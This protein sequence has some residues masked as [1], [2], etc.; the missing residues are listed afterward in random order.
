MIAAGLAAILVATCTI[1]A[2]LAVV[3]LDRPLE[4]RAR[5]S[6][7]AWAHDLIARLQS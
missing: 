1:L 7:E 3:C 6:A 2:V 4:R 5:Q